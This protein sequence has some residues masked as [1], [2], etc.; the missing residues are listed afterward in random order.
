LKKRNLWEQQEGE[1]EPQQHPN[2]GR[3]Y[4]LQLSQF[5]GKF[6]QISVESPKKNYFY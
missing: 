3:Y 5:G 2:A 6:S 4:V 1:K